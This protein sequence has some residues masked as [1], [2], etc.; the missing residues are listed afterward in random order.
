[1]ALTVGELVGFLRLDDR[2]FSQ[3][4][5]RARQDMQATAQAGTQGARQVQESWSS[6]TRSII[7][8][9]ALFKTGDFFR[10]AISAAS[11]LEQAVGG[12]EAVFGEWADV[13]D[14]AAQ[15]SATSIGMSE[16]AF[17]EATSRIGGQLKNMGFDM[18]DAAD[19]SIRLTNIA[20]DLAAT[21]GGSTTEAVEALGAA[22]RGE[23]DPAERFGLLLH[24]NAVNAKAVE[25]GLAESVSSVDAWAKAQATLALITEQ[26]ADA[27]GQFAREADTAAGRAQILAAQWEN[28]QAKIGQRLL[29]VLTSLGSVLTGVLDSGWTTAAVGVGAFGTALMLAAPKVSDFINRLRSL[30][31]GFGRIA[32]IG[33]GVGAAGMIIGLVEGL[34]ALDEEN[35]RRN[36]QETAQ[37]FVAMGENFERMTQIA[38]EVPFFRSRRSLMGVFDELL[39]TNELAAERW[40][41]HARAAG[42]AG[43]VI[44][45]MEGKLERHRRATQQAAEDQERM[46]NQMEAAERRFAKYA[47]AIRDVDGVLQQLHNRY[48]AAEDAMAKQQE[49]VDGLDEHFQEMEAQYGAAAYSLDLHTE[50]GRRNHEMLSELFA[51]THDTISAMVESGATS[52]ELRAQWAEDRAELGRVIDRFREAGVDVSRYD[53]LLGEIDRVVETRATFQ[54]WASA[55]LR[56]VKGLVDLLDGAVANVTVN[57]R[58]GGWSVLQAVARRVAGREG[59]AY[60]GPVA[61]GRLYEVVEQG[62]PELLVEGSRTYLIPARDGR[63]VPMERAIASAAGT[64][65][66]VR[67]PALGAGSAGGPGPGGAGVHVGPINV[68]GSVLSERDLIRVIRDAVDR[69]ALRGVAA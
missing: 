39:A 50:A 18:A 3:Q 58:A 7:E 35:R 41:E 37:T 15:R 2:G 24:Q 64:V 47:D 21:Y 22:L 59:R 14:E 52:E 33:G 29:P 63:V 36:W 9:Y 10:G 30:E 66:A 25:M 1:M 13:I 27:Q 55:G 43:D 31:G 49:L 34:R 65:P 19:W 8:G 12:T 51:A 23:A 56:R 45:E 26:S 16:R 57:L 38:R 42:A 5:Q 54:D 20:A 68:T 17:R 69:G 40:I 62:A 4:L 32:R 53:Q 60:G 28:L 61:A 48:F 6:L 67:P 11:E 44:A 46:N